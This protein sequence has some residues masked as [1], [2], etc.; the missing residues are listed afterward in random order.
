[1]TDP[2]LLNHVFRVVD[3]ETFA[4]ARDSAWLRELFAP[5]ELRTTR[6]PDWAYTGLYWYGTTTYLELFEEGA[7]G[8]PGASGMAF[9]V[10]TPGAT[11]AIATAW[12]DALGDAEHRLVVRPLGDEAVPWFHIA[13]A[14]PDHRGRLKLWSMEYH[15]DFLASWHPA[16]TAARGI[17]R[18]EILERYAAVSPGPAAPLL[19]DVVAA[20]LAVTPGERGFFERHAAAF[21]VETRDV[22]A[23]R[24]LSSGDLTIGLSDADDGRHGVQ[25]IVCRLRRAAGREVL[26]IGRSTI[27]VDGHRLVWKFRDV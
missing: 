8:P 18:A 22:G 15:A 6:R 3:G 26:R 7:Q 14:R 19:D 17:T 5:S 2:L 20:T 9:A 16:H 4:A 24:V 13:H 25:E 10:E 12:H 1:M 27:T 21:A 11:A 23:S